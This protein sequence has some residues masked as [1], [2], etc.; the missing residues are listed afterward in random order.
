MTSVYEEARERGGLGPH[1]AELL[2]KIVDS[3]R[4]FRSF[5]PPPDHTRWTADAIADVAHDF[6]A[7]D[8]RRN[9]IA[10]VL[11]RASDEESFVRLL[12]TAVR[13]FMIDGLRKT[14][15]GAAMRSLRRILELDP[16]IVE[17]PPGRPGAGA[18][19]IGEFSDELPYAGDPSR[20]VKAAFGVDDVRR[21]R[22]RPDARNRAP[23][24][25]AD[26]LQRVVHS[27]LQSAAAPVTK[28][29]VLDVVVQR[30]PLIDSPVAVEL[31]EEQLDPLTPIVAA[32]SSAIALEI[33]NDL[34]D[35][36]RL[37]VGMIDGT[38]REIAEET[39]LSK[40][41]AHRA[42]VSARAAL[43]IH[44]SDESDMVGIVTRLRE[45]FTNAVSKGTQRAGLTS[46]N[47]E[48]R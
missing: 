10:G 4:R 26:S 39:G 33:W 18:W 20:L 5:P 19:C 15:T 43:R 41:A 47:S 6:L 46:D 1:G 17:V 28:A 9:R 23:I 34:N 29:L 16:T 12:E 32:S 14:D 48:E 30:F 36:E 7:E 38:V 13:N 27:I 44:L 35:V 2:Y 42:M 8:T 31:R 21:A 11:L 24:A 45:L 37:V 25:E 3:V 40:S 22:W